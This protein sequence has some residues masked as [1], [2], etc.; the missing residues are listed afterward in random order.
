MLVIGHRGCAEQYPENTVTAVEASAQHVDLVE[1]D[2]VQSGSGELVAFHDETLDRL[3]AASGR[4]DETPVETLTDLHVDGSEA[5]IPRFDTVVDA[6]PAGVG[7]NLDVHDPTIVD[8]ALD[9][10]DGL[11]GQ[12]LLSSTDTQTIQAARTHPRAVTI[13]YSFDAEPEA[14]LPRARELG[15]TFVHVDYRLCLE[16]SVI[17]RAHRQGIQVDAWTLASPGPVE[18]L[19]S[20]GV[21][22]VTVDRWDIV[23]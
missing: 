18:K 14:E 9:T 22:A 13:G 8:R 17:E 6:W 21:D 12:V 5:T 15:A 7:M 16:S 10:L 23:G 2:V 19:R 11:D 3:T 4:V 20:R 1:V